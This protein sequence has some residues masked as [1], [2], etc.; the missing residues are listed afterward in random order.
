MRDEVVKP[1]V[2]AIIPARG[3]SKSILRKNVKLFGGHPLL[4]YSIAAGLE[5]K[6][7]DRVIVSTDDPEMAEIARS[8]GA[9]VP[10]MR[11]A[12]LAEDLTPDYPVITHCI[13]WLRKNEGYDPE[14]ILQLRP[15]S[16]I[17]PKGLVDDA[18]RLLLNDPEADSVRGVVPSGQN[19]YKMWR[20]GE[21]YMTPLMAGEFPEPYNM[22]RQ[23]LPPTYW[24]TGHIDAIR[25]STIDRKMTLTGDKVIPLTLDP[26]FTVDI[27]NLF[28][29]ERYEWLLDKLGDRA[30]RCEQPEN[31][32]NDS[33]GS[34]G[35][36]KPTFEWG[37]VKLAVFDFDGVMTDNK[38][39]VDQ[40]GVE[41]ARCDRSDGL[42]IGMLLA[43]EVRAVVLSKEE[44]PVV[45][46][47]CRKLK[48]ECIQ[49]I[50][51][52][53]MRFLQLLADE[54]VTAEETVYVGNDINDIGCI[55]LAGCGV[56]VADSHPEV[57]HV[58]DYTLKAC[59][60]NGAVRELCDLIISRK[61]AK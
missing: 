17:R 43:A 54:G 2:V 27:D 8:Y 1:K 30:V 59:G 9:E 7:V 45:A 41:S 29:W 57:L 35:T 26:L 15:T 39:Y 60:G 52:K 18:V 20:L 48:M 14:V 37:R 58:A 6:L 5:S 51:D 13:E 31:G 32:S 50:D 61:T 19:P 4:A 46:A 44:N 38:V 40:N 36:R 22:P 21:R 25:V 42:G 10:F 55:E 56:A 24:Q 34:Y 12:E 53:P 3:G 33:N 16:P 23:K 49:G 28:D 47:R 11:P